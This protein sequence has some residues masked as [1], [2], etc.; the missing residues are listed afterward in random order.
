M[1][2]AENAPI[3]MAPFFDRALAGEAIEAAMVMA[4]TAAMA[5]ARMLLVISVFPLFG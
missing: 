1:A 5:V 3:A 4:A 2:R